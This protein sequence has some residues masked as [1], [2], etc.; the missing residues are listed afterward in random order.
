MMSS[1]HDILSGVREPFPSWLL[2]ADEFSAE[3]FFSSRV[4]Y[5]PGSGSDGQAFDVFSRTHSAHCVLHIDQNNCP[6]DM[7]DALGQDILHRLDGYERRV[8]TLLPQVHSAL[9]PEIF[10]DQQVRSVESALWILLER[11]QNFGDEHGPMRIAFLHIQAEAVWACRKVWSTL[12]P[13]PFAVILQDHGYSDNW[14][15]FGGENSPLFE[16]Q[17]QRSLPKWLLVGERTEPWPTYIE[18]SEPTS[19]AGEYGRTRK[20]FRQQ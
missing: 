8:Q 14:T 7:E 10:P 17:R 5:Y 12:D 15:K 11:Q 2:T 18:A 3:D 9:R 16:F 13:E 20:L 19:P 6:L 4:V 1:A